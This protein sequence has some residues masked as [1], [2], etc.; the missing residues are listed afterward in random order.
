MS[1]FT[2]LLPRR[3]DYAGV[4]HGWKADLVAGLVAG[5]FGGSNVQVSGPTGVIADAGCS[6]NQCVGFEC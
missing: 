2:E 3:G 4:P 6:H 1:R 5:V